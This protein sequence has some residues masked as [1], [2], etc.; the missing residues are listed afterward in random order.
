MKGAGRQSDGCGVLTFRGFCRRFKEETSNLEAIPPL[1]VKRYFYPADNATARESD[2][3][4]DLAT[5]EEP[6]NCWYST[7]SGNLN[8]GIRV[9][10]VGTT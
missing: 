8:T 3:M 4:W 9:A 2:A 7:A 10:V 5:L 6:T 1:S